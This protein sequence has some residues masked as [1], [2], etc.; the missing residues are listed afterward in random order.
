MKKNLY[1]L[2]SN[3]NNY[4]HHVAN[5]VVGHRRLNQL[6]LVINE[7]ARRPMALKL[8]ARKL[9]TYAR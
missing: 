4:L 5:E 3:N 6:I 7:L 8:Q 9:L 1:A 2:N